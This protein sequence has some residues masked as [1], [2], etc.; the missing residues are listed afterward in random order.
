[1]ALELF[2]YHQ[3]MPSYL[4]FM[5]LFGQ[6]AGPNDMRFSGFREQICLTPPVPANTAN[7][8]TDLRRSGRHYELSYNLKTVQPKD[9]NNPESWSVRQAGLYHGFDV[10]EGITLWI[11]TKGLNALDGKHDLKENIEEITG[12]QGREEDRKFDDANHCFRS[13]LAIHAMMIHWATESWR[14]Y[15]QWLDE[16]IEKETEP[17]VSGSRA[18]GDKGRK[19][20]TGEDVQ[21]IQKLEDRVNEVIMAVNGNMEVLIALH[22]F[23]ENIVKHPDWPLA[24]TATSHVEIFAKQAKNAVYDLRMQSSRA[25]ALGKHTSE[26]KNLVSE[27]FR[28]TP[29][30]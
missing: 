16:T 9:P 20:Y 3:V 8:L 14:W 7:H 29:S 28:C 15:L 11:I 2:T 30:H 4:D 12:W 24:A 6:S 1:M 26:R 25:T 13:T 5:M 22:T 10:I 19:W 27:M 23:Y 18:R 21:R 17:A